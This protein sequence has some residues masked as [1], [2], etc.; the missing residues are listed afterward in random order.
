MKIANL[1]KIGKKENIQSLFCD[2]EIFIRRVLVFRDIEAKE[3]GDKL[4]N[5][6]VNYQSEQV[7]CS[8]A[9]ID[10]ST[11]NGLIGQVQ[12]T[13][14]S[15]NP[16][17]YCMYAFTPEGMLKKQLIHSD[18]KDFG[19]AALFIFNVQK[20]LERIQ[21]ECI[22]KGIGCKS[23]LVTYEDFSSYH[24]K[25]SPFVKDHGFAHQ[26]EFRILFEVPYDTSDTS[27]IYIGSLQDI[28]IL[29]T[30]DEINEELKKR[31]QQDCV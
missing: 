11:E 7:E 2:G 31:Y 15:N 26:S 22:D 20:F 10:F 5:L 24:G 1:V 21:K 30:V 9:G 18:N 17:S 4:E 8:W 28:A 29:G 27:K 3:I 23:K 12:I 25:V 6:L 13:D 16:F 19:D 14:L